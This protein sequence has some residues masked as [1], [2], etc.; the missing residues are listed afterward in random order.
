MLFCVAMVTKISVCFTLQHEEELER[1]RKEEEARKKKEEEERRKRIE[2]GLETE[3]EQGDIEEGTYLISCIFSILT[4]CIS[5]Q[6]YNTNWQFRYRILHELSF[7]LNFYETCLR[8]VIKQASYPGC[9]LT[10]VEYKY[11]SR[12]YY[13]EN[14]ACNVIKHKTN[15]NY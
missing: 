9:Y 7:H 13:L 4:V 1:K 11:M 10:C 6:L 8:D 15:I 12:L 5:Y 3:S 14:K 2:R